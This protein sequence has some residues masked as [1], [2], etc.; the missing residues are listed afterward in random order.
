MRRCVRAGE[1]HLFETK[2]RVSSLYRPFNDFGAFH[3]TGKVADVTKVVNG[4]VGTRGSAVVS[5]TQ[6]YSHI[7][8][9]CDE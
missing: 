2:G 5:Y 8:L 9:H 6:M 4:G 3:F 1:K 7:L